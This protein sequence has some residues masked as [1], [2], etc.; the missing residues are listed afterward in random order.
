[1]ITF[2]KEHT[3]RPKTSFCEPRIFDEGGLQANYLFQR[4][5][6]FAGLQDRAP[7]AF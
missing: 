4:E 7:P 1:M 6:V 2:A 5:P 3:V